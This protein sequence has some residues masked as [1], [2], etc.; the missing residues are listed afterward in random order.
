LDVAVRH[1]RRIV[2]NDHKLR[3]HLKALNKGGHLGSLH[4]VPGDTEDG[5]AWLK[6]GAR[7]SKKYQV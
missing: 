2:T 5:V 4:L 6:G 1:G 7:D 3:G